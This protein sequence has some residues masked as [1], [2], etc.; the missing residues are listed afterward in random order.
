MSERGKAA[1]LQT[2]EGNILKLGGFRDEATGRRRL[3]EY[4]GNGSRQ[5]PQLL[6]PGSA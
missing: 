3:A 1:K 4:S 6:N 5:E 2:Q